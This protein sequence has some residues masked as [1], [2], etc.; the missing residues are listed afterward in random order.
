MTGSLRWP[1]QAGLTKCSTLFS[2]KISGLRRDVH[3]GSGAMENEAN[4]KADRA[5][6]NANEKIRLMVT[7]KKIEDLCKE[8]LKL[9]S[10]RSQTHRG[11]YAPHSGSVTGSLVGVEQ[12]EPAAALWVFW[13]LGILRLVSLVEGFKR[14]LEAIKR[15][16]VAPFSS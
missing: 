1:C 4:Q 8:A 12:G 7:I 11:S 13:G 2:T 16:S 6:D 9:F 5:V 3:D 14:A 15:D 10:R